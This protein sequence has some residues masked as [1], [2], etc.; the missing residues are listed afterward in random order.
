MRT[1]IVIYLLLICSI[2]TVSAQE[3]ESFQFWSDINGSYFFSKKTSLVGDIGFRLYNSHPK[4]RQWII[5]PGIKHSV[6]SHWKLATG[7][8]YFRRHFISESVVKEL[9]L[10]QGV[11]YV[12]SFYKWLDIQNYFRLEE[13]F[14]NLSTSSFEFRLRNQL[15]VKFNI[16]SKLDKKI[17]IPLSA[18]ILGS[19]SENTTDIV[20]WESFRFY[21]GLGYLRPGKWKIEL[22]GQ[23]QSTG[24]QLFEIPDVAKE[25][26]FRLRFY[27]YFKS[28][29]AKDKKI[30]DKKD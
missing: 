23:Y 25:Y 1:R 15:Q 9:R 10:Y 20:S 18:E 3:Q 13:R 5:R 24:L 6:N 7:F 22:Q 21:S 12:T 11:V 2:R 30:D 4:W 26:M 14:Y 16:V 8:G 27:I 29:Y 17:Y 19:V 28:S